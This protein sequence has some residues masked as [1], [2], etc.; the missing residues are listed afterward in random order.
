MRALGVDPG[1]RATGYG[2]VESRG[3]ELI[4]IAAGVIR[5]PEGALA[6]RLSHIHAEL[7]Q[8]IET[9]HPELVAVEAV[10]TAHNARSALVLGHAR[11]V[12]LAACGRA[13]LDV[14]EYAPAQVKSAVVGSGR[15]SKPQVQQMVR[16]ILSLPRAPAAD[17]ADALAVAICHLHG[18]PLRAA[19]QRAAGP[20]KPSSS[21]ATL[22]S[23]GKVRRAISTAPSRPRTPS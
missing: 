6:A 14:A 7:L 16:A 9:W 23:R 15:A 18:A 4:L 10:F 11:G 22:G 13:G 5:P 20:A 17:A 1:S 21:L 3:R 19:I 2:I 8:L 12:A